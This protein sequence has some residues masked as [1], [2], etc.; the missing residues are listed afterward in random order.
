MKG[1]GDLGAAEDVRDDLAWERS[2]L[3]AECD[4]SRSADLRDRA[5]CLCVSVRLSAWLSEGFA[6]GVD[7]CVGFA[8]D[9]LDEWVERVSAA[10]AGCVSFGFPGGFSVCFAEVSVAQEARDE[11]ALD[12]ELDDDDDALGVELAQNGRRLDGPPSSLHGFLRLLR[13]LHS[14]TRAL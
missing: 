14:S 2:G 4:E 12:D 11:D 13:F 1:R 9:E 6:W 7:E 10:F 8:D 3:G 5:S